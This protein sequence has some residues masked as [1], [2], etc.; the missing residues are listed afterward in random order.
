MTKFFKEPLIHFLLA[1]A[2]MFVL[3]G[4]VGD[5]EMEAV[6]KTEEIV[7]TSGRLESLTGQ[8][9]KVWQ[10]PP[11][12][13]ELQG[14]I[15]EHVCEE[16]MYREA[17][18]MGLDRDDTIVRRR[19]RQKLEFLSE[20]IVSLRDPTE[21]DLAAYLAAHPDDFRVEPVLSFKQV[22]LNPD[23][24]GDQIDGVALGLLAE[25]SRAGAGADASKLGDNL[26]LGHEFEAITRRDIANRFGREFTMAVL[27]APE[28]EWYGPVRS[29]FGSHLVF[30]RERVDS[31]IPSLAEVRDQVTRDW[32]A[33]EREAANVGF[34]N[35]L[36]ARYRVTVENGVDGGGDQTKHAANSEVG[37]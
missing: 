15:D 34:Y 23:R 17:L 9:A 19:M 2:G 1:G 7:I 33:A 28:G 6:V 32:S 20:D 31:R 13:K 36:R 24:H 3:F 8:F 11:T 37:E 35:G 26:L 29:G 4:M 22:Y 16:I 25:L 12:A 21:E 10:R 18:A 27:E 5:R 30:I 14:L